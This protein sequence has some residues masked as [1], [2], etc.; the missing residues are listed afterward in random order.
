[1][2]ISNSATRGY[3]GLLVC[4]MMMCGPMGGSRYESRRVSLKDYTSP[5][6]ASSDTILDIPDIETSGSLPDWANNANGSKAN[7]AYGNL[8]LSFEANQGQTDSSVRF[9]SRA[10][11]QILFLTSTEA[12]LSLRGRD[13]TVHPDRTAPLIEPHE[14]RHSKVGSNPSVLRMKLLGANPSPRVTGVDEMPGKSNYFIGND[15]QKWQTNVS[16]YAKV[17]YEQVYPGV[18]LVYYG[19]QSQL[20]YDLIVAPGGDPRRIRLAFE[21]AEKVRIDEHGDLILSTPLGQVLQHKPFAY[22]EVGGKKEPVVAQYA[23]LGPN[24]IGFKVTR[25]DSAKPLV[26]DPVLAYSTYLGGS[27]GDTGNSIA[28]DS[29]GNAY[30]TGSTSSLDFPTAS[31]LQPNQNIA[32]CCLGD[33]FVTKL[34]A[35]GTALIYST[36]IGGGALDQSNGIAVDPF[37]NA[38]ITGTTDSI[39]FPTANAFR[40]NH[41]GIFSD[42]FVVKLTF[43]GSAFVYSTYLG[44]NRHDAATSIAADASGNAYVTGSTGSADFPTSHPLQPNLIGSGP[45]IFITKFDAT[46]TSLVYSTYLGGVGGETG[47]GIAVDVAGNAYIAGTTSS[48]DFPLVNPVQPE[49]KDKTVFKSIDGAS[50]WAGINNGLPTQ[51]VV[52]TI[53]IDPSAPDTLYVGTNGG[54]V[55][56]STDAGKSW[57]GANNG[58]FTLGMD[59]LLIDPTT[60]STLYGANGSLVR[61]TDGGLSWN[62]MSLGGG[63]SVVAIDP[64]SPQN[65]YAAM[66]QQI[67]KSTDSGASWRGIVVRDIFPNGNIASTLQSLVVD[68]GTPSTIYAGDI[69][70]VFKST[71]GGNTWRGRLGGTSIDRGIAIDPLNRSSLYVWGFGIS[72]SADGGQTWSAINSGLSSKVVHIVAIDPTATNTLYAGTDR[73]IQ[74]STD[75][76]GSWNTTA[77]RL[78][79]A[80]TNAIAIDPRVTST[81]YAG[82]DATFDCFVAKL[83]PQGTALLYS[84]Y[85]GGDTS[86]FASGIAVDTFGNAYVAGATS[87]PGF[88]ARNPV[89]PFGGGLLDGFVTKLDTVHSE[90]VYSTHLGGGSSDSCRGIAVDMAGN[91][92]VTGQTLSTDFPTKAPLQGSLADGDG[93][94]FVAKLNAKGS[95]LVFSTYWGGGEGAFHSSGFDFANAIAIDHEGGAYVTGST[96][97]DNFPTTP[98]AFQLVR[99][100]SSGTAFVAK[101]SD[102]PPFDMCLQDDGNGSILRINTATGDYQ[103]VICGG[104][105]FTGAGALA[106]RGCLI[107]LQVNG[108]D[109]RLQASIDTCRNSAT[110]SMQVLSQGRTF[111]ILDRNTT[112]NTCVCAGT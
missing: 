12:V 40:P 3:V 29:A 107:T 54:G 73:G 35:A 48:P 79:N 18:D 94:P 23:K 5:L 38:Y 33:V 66:G 109:R 69:G 11:G 99:R 36:Y 77:N 70:G 56:K 81:L 47:N 108:P 37:G 14:D 97:S 19:N 95:A 32:G 16:N 101:I 22:Q 51:Y 45:D 50:T 28:V 55:F 100:G 98:G 82:T 26:I 25:Y 96:A 57:I 2:R 110:A 83:S 85:L 92:Y 30:I 43:A 49:I 68:P 63:V 39:D 13:R 10:G 65:L 46:G 44:G 93:D 103:F 74:K 104:L 84:T 72:K 58:L 89:Q 17:K 90:I 41:T 21:G 20:E 53:A 111:T 87:S 6:S 34:N 86:D 7:K 8:P 112:N 42:A 60:T 31:P 67:F 78:T 102:P 61:S 64:I 24:H 52:K 9:I 62:T 71:D 80:S 59:Q 15:P 75:G 88:P 1:M 105:T 91:A 106:R 27:R 4:A 76:G